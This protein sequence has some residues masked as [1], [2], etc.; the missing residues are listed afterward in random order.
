MSAAPTIAFLFPGQGMEG[1]RTGLDLAA[2]DPPAAELLA[3]AAAR[4]GRDLRRALDRGE[5]CLART[6]VLQPLLTAVSL[7]A[8]G[9][10]R[11]EGLRPAFV[12]GHSLGELAAWAAAG[13]P[14]PDGT[15]DLAAERGRI[16]AESA[17]RHPGG[18]LAVFVSEDR[19]EDALAAGR[20]VGPCDLA[21]HNAPDEWV[22]SGPR[23]VLAAV[24]AAYPSRPLTA[25]GPWHGAL[26]AEALAAWSATLAATRPPTAAGPAAVGEGACPA[27]VA[28]A[29]GDVAPPDEIPALLAGQLCRPVRWAESLGRLVAL[30]VTDVVTVGPGRVLRSLL[31]RTVG[32]A[33]R[34]HAAERPDELRRTAETLLDAGRSQGEAA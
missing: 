20:R 34:V 2:H 13:G 1:P 22:L 14:E 26:M 17:A 8:L 11:R 12:A 24:A 21:A 23:E 27:F 15:V 28:N 18:L 5:P 19:L 32:A 6:E 9:V 25:V 29:T 31:T 30:G 16:M 4:C 7:G 10:L 3:R 33:L